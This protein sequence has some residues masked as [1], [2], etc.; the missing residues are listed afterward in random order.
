MGAFQRN[1]KMIS[2]FGF[3]RSEVGR[4]WQAGA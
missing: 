2:N 3:V 4:N 1:C